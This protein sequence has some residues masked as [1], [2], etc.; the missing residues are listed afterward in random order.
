MLILDTSSSL[1]DQ[2][3]T[4]QVGNNV[5]WFSRDEALVYEKG[6][7]I[8]A[9]AIYC[10]IKR[11]F[12]NLHANGLS[13]WN[14]LRIHL[15]QSIRDCATKIGGSVPIYMTVLIRIGNYIFCL[16]DFKASLSNL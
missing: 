3:E 2:L 16:S 4:N 6:D 9:T 5:D 12:R 10:N 1:A 13:D 15:V 11:R 7:T 14:V 8:R